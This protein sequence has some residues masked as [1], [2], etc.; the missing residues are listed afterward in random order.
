MHIKSRYKAH[1]YLGKLDTGMIYLFCNYM[2]QNCIK[3]FLPF[4]VD[5]NGVYNLVCGENIATPMVYHEMPLCTGNLYNY[6]STTY[7]I[8]SFIKCEK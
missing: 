7:N 2:A 1:V 6:F 3:H 4:Q 8:D 5:S